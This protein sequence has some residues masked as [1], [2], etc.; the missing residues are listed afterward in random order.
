MS[1]VDRD[2]LK[3]VVDRLFDNEKEFANAKAEYSEYK[4]DVFTEIKSKVEETGVTLAE[5]KKVLKVRMDFTAAVE[6]H[7]A[8]DDAITTVKE[9]W[10]G[11][12]DEPEDEDE[13]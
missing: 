12:L 8:L 9:V 1:N 13:V 6:E 7:E 4:K 5:V 10:D 3:N 11:E 2:Y